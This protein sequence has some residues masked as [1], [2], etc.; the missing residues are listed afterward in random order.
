MGTVWRLRLPRGNNHG[1]LIPIAR[2]KHR[3]ERLIMHGT[4]ERADIKPVA[5]CSGDGQ[6]MLEEC[7][8]IPVLP[9]LPLPPFPPF[10][11]LPPFLP[12]PPH[13][14]ERARRHLPPRGSLAK[15]FDGRSAVDRERT[16][17]GRSAGVESAPSQD[18]L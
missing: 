11:P 17:F 7:P 9:F 4:R 8:G 13:E 2:S 14:N 18:E 1:R 15:L 6:R 16:E 5:R 10:L 12:F 3:A